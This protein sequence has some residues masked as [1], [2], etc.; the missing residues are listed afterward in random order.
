MG[1]ALP[2]RPLKFV[3]SLVLLN[4]YQLSMPTFFNFRVPGQI[5]FSLNY[6][7][8]LGSKD[9]HAGSA[10]LVAAEMAGKT[11]THE[12]RWHTRP[13]W[14]DLAAGLRPAE[15]PDDSVTLGEWRHGL[16]FYGSDVLEQNTWAGLLQDL[17]LKNV[18]L[19][20]AC[21]CFLAESSG[22]GN[23]GAATE[24]GR[25]KSSRHTD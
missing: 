7:Q 18:A 3:I 25:G 10:C 1:W 17:V 6:L 14:I 5:L 24:G 2:A 21:L 8:S 20:G 4:F 15:L 12:G 16:Q 22:A 11:C 19:A 9:H 23:G 13:L